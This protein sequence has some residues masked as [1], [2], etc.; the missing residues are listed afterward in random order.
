MFGSSGTWENINRKHFGIAVGSLGS[1]NLKPLGQD[2]EKGKK[3]RG[4]KDLMSGQFER[5][6]GNSTLR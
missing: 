3:K 6:L 4:G 1:R 5:V 2:L